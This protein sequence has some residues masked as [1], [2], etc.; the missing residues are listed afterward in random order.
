MKKLLSILLTAFITMTVVNTAA[1]ADAAKGQKLYL[2]KLRKAFGGMNGAKF[3]GM[4]SQEEWEALFAND[5]AKFIDA[6][7]SKYPK[8]KKFLKGKGFK[9]ILPHIKDFAIEYANDSGNV[10]SCS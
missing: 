7:G 6:M 2:K 3:A 8:S 9:K 4:H 5:G 10:P 1:Y